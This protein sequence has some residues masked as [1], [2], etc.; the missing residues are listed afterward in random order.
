MK[1]AMLS[2]YLPSG[3]KGGVGYQTHYLS[4]QLVELGHQVTVYSLYEKPFDALYEVVTVCLKNKIL[5]NKILKTFAFAY[6][7]KKIDFTEFDII[8]SQGD[9]YF[10]FN[11]K[12]PILRTFN[13]T[14]I[15][16][17]IHAKTIGM[18]LRQL[19]LYPLEYFSAFRCDYSVSI[20]ENTKRFIPLIKEVI[21]CGVDINYIQNGN[22]MKS[23]VP[24]I[25]FV[26]TIEGRKRGELLVKQFIQVIKPNIPNSELWMVSDKNV[27]GSGIINYGRVDTDTLFE[28]YRK[29]WVFCMPSSYE[30]FGVPYIEAMAAGSAVVATANVGAQEILMNGR[31][32]IICKDKKLGVQIVELLNNVKERDDF[33]KNS[34]NEVGKYDWSNVTKKYVDL[35][36]RVGKPRENI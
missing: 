24:S 23:E 28:L 10:L 13:G 36:E 8:H 30:G 16:E 7:L 15:M 21:P 34:L 12:I 26:G 18:F 1:I 22:A 33:I 6:A 29:S 5:N 3:S 31:Y 11:S 20:S 4:N 2:K 25:L 17:A 19:I 35:Y 14:A 32:G 27:Y 9:D